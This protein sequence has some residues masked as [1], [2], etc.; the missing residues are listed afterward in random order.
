VVEESG[1]Q[2]EE[3]KDEGITQEEAAAQEEA[4]HEE[5]VFELVIPRG[6]ATGIVF[7]AAEKFGL[8][9]DQ[10][11]RDEDVPK[12]VLRGNSKEVIEKAHRFIYEKHKQWI[13][14]LEE[15]RRMRRERILRKLRKK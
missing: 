1:Q 7:E 4:P 2:Q 5:G 8:D 6:I 14:S 15:Q 3:K 10:E 13:E 11:V 12:I 9:I